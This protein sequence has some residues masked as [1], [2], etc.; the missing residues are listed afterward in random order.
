MVICVRAGMAA[1]AH[2][3]YERLGFVRLPEKDWSP[4]PGIDLLGLR[5]DLT[6]AG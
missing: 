4:L 3:L 6:A 2:R 1:N 5:L